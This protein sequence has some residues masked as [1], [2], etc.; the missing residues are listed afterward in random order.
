MQ[1][2]KLKKTPAQRKHTRS[3]NSPWARGGAKKIARSEQWRKSQYPIQLALLDQFLKDHNFTLESMHAFLV[4]HFDSEAHIES[5]EDDRPE[6]KSSSAVAPPSNPEPGLSETEWEVVELEDIVYDTT[7]GSAYR[8]PHSAASSSTDTSSAVPKDVEPLAGFPHTV[9]APSILHPAPLPIPSG[10]CAAKQEV[11]PWNEIQVHNILE[12][13]PRNP[14]RIPQ[15]RSKEDPLAHVKQRN[16]V[17]LLQF[18]TPR[19]VNEWQD[20]IGASTPEALPFTLFGLHYP[21]GSEGPQIHPVRDCRI[22]SIWDDPEAQV[23]DVDAD[24]GTP[25][26]PAHL[27]KDFF[28]FGPTP[29]PDEASSV[30]YNMRD[31]VYFIPE[32][33]TQGGYRWAL[34]ERPGSAGVRVRQRFRDDGHSRPP[35]V[36]PSL[37]EI[38]CFTQKRSMPPPTEVDVSDFSLFAITQGF[39]SGS[40]FRI[41][42]AVQPPNMDRFWHGSNLYCALSMYKQGPLNHRPSNGPTAVYC[43]TNLRGHKVSHYCHYILSGSG[44]AWT[45]FAQFAIPAGKTKKYSVDQRYAQAEDIIM[46]ALWFHGVPQSQFTAECI[47]L[48]WDP[49]IEIDEAS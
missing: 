7:K 18:A 30:M 16:L 24:Y 9:E 36:F 13:E 17:G 42:M 48:I 35:T 22:A 31:P 33:G 27:L 39:P 23:L 41:Q 40:L 43:F 32:H 4:E 49:A 34:G 45:S 3:V 25:F 29:P 6:W 46:T 19:L 47:W 1:P 5:Q 14:P 28:D 8:T 26:T 11:Y 37:E 2:V 38:S 12:K 15:L 10:E 20:A 44:C 21:S